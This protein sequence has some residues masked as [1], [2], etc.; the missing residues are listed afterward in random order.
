[1]LKLNDLKPNK[2]SKKNK[3]RVARGTSSGWGKTAG[4][5]HKGQKSRSGGTKGIRFEGGQTPLY[6]RLPKRGFK[7]YPFRKEYIIVNVSQLNKLDGEV[8]KESLKISGLL[9]ILGDGEIS[10]AITVKADKFS[11]TAKKK[12]EAAGGKCIT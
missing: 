9:K 4:R 10:K 7:N 5:G 12:I 3:K 11:K 2:G 8:S 1:M 6:R